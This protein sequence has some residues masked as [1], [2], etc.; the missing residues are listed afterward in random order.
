MSWQ[1]IVRQIH[2][3]QKIRV[4]AICDPPNYEDEAARLDVRLKKLI[5]KNYCELSPKMIADCLPY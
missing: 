5:G 4:V 1:E 2:A 3:L